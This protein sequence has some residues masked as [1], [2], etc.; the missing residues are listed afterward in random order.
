MGYSE[1]LSNHGQQQVIPAFPQIERRVLPNLDMGSNLDYYLFTKFMQFNQWISQTTGSINRQTSPLKADFDYDKI[2]NYD[3]SSFQA[4]LRKMND[5][6]KDQLKLAFD[7]SGNRREN[8]LDFVD[9]KKIEQQEK[10][11]RSL[12]FV[13]YIMAAIACDTIMKWIF[14]GL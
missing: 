5:E 13:G 6:Q 12:R 7:K 11:G 8:E 2:I 14:G 1:I 9:Y 10:D 3:Q 4:A